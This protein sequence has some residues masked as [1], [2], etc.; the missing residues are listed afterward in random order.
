MS[1]VLNKSDICIKSTWDNLDTDF[2]KIALIE[3]LSDIVSTYDSEQ[4]I[5]E[6]IFQDTGLLYK[7]DFTVLANTSSNYAQVCFRNTESFIIFKLH[8]DNK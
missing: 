3:F 6:R 8:Y 7:T 4:I 1:K 2:N 5:G